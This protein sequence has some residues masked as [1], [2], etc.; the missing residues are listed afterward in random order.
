MRLYR[1]FGCSFNQIK[2]YFRII[3]E[4]VVELGWFP[5]TRNTSGAVQDNIGRGFSDNV[6][7]DR[8]FK[9]NRHIRGDSVMPNV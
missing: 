8:G 3:S 5:G 4:N 1:K 7:W 6:F 9:I 2:R